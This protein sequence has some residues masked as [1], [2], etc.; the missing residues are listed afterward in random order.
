MNTKAAY[1]VFKDK[2][3]AWLNRKGEMNFVYYAVAI[4]E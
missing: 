2:R 1:Q 4:Y 3:F